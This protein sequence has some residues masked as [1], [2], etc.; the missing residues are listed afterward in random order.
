MPEELNRVA[1]DHLSD[2]LLCPTPASVDNLAKEGLRDRAVLVGDVMYDAALLFR[3]IAA[4]QGGPFAERWQSKQFAL[5]TIH[6]A[7][8]T[9]DPERLRRILEAL[10]LI[11]QTICPVVLPLHPR[12]RSRLASMSCNPVHVN[13]IDPV[14]YLQMLLLETRARFILTDSGGV[15][16][17]AYFARVPCITMRDETEWV[18][19]LDNNCNILAGAD[20]GRILAAAKSNDGAGPWID[21]YGS[22]HAGLHILK[23]LEARMLR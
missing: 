9:D 4:R 18:E 12:T 6:R 10:D 22:G 20:P 17:E 19:T 13:V 8:N 16:K 7:E 23:A 21:C 3:E 11:A 2:L 14:S 1:T 5:A 15:Q